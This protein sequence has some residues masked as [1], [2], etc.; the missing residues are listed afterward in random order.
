MC[1][2]VWW[3]N[4]H[5]VISATGAIAHCYG[6]K[7]VQKTVKKNITHN[8]EYRTPFTFQWTNNGR[9]M[10]DF[11]VSSRLG[12]LAVGCPNKSSCVVNVTSDNIVSIVRF[13]H[14]ELG[15]DLKL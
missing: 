14:Q 6:C 9:C 1:E 2:Y 8:L 3:A 11:S 15:I 7:T 10:A 5:T 13:P 12:Q 4:T